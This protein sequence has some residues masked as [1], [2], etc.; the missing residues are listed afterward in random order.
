MINLVGL[1]LLEPAHAHVIHVTHMR[2]AEKTGLQHRDLVFFL[3]P[4]PFNRSILRQEHVT[5]QTDAEMQFRWQ[6]NHKDSFDKQ[7]R[8]ALRQLRIL[9]G[10]VVLALAAVLLGA[11][12]LTTRGL[13]RARGLPA[14]GLPAWFGGAGI[15]AGCLVYGLA[16]TIYWEYESDL[17]R[18]IW[19]SATVVKEPAA[20]SSDRRH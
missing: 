12:V 15:A 1:W 11:C 4:L 13:R 5:Q 3:R 18:D 9:R 19:L 8:G 7:L 20:G 16:M 14:R 6:I 17:H 2:L 10:L